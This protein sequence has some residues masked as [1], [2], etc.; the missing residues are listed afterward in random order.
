MSIFC[1][2]YAK[3]ITV[4]FSFSLILF[5]LTLSIN[6]GS[7]DF[8]FYKNFSIEHNLK[9]QVG[10]SQDN[11][12]KM[13][14]SLQGQIKTGDEKE[15]KQY[16]NDREVSHMK[17]VYKLFNLNRNINRIMMVI[18]IISSTLVY[19]NK[20]DKV[21]NSKYIINYLLIILVG[22]LILGGIVYFNFE[23]SFIK[24][25]EL[26]FNNDLWLLN[27]ETDIMIRMLPQ[28]F[29]M[30][31]AFKIFSIFILFMGIVIAS[32]IIFIFV[33]KRGKRNVSV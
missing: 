7:E 33:K 25:H 13:Y 4:L 18:V 11:L 17:D 10:V 21:Q 22:F 6:I 19:Y 3:L 16:F 30:S 15:I 12:E 24:F 29:F 27:P 23:S 20:E 32:L 26:F 5:L 14:K 9:N 28:E 8:N 2:K 1:K 31:I